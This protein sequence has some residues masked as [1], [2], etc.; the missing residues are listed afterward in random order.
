M[1]WFKVDDKFHSHAKVARLGD[2]SDALALWVV[3]GS[4]CADQLTDGWIPAYVARR[5]DPDSV[6]RAAAL[7]RV[8]LWKE[9]IQEGEKGWL[10]HGWNDEGRQP[11]AE[12][13]QQER[14]LK[15]ERQRRWREKHRAESGR[16][17]VD[18]S[19]ASGAG[20][21]AGDG[22]EFEVGEAENDLM[23]SPHEASTAASTRDGAPES[24]AGQSPKG[25]RDVDASTGRLGD[26]GVDTAPTRP[27]PT[28]DKEQHLPPSAD[29]DGAVNGAAAPKK[30]APDPMLRFPDF[31]AVYPRKVGKQAAEK[32]WA[33]AVKGGADPQAIIDGALAYAYECRLRDQD[34][35]KYPQGWLTDGRWMDERAPTLPIDITPTL[36]PWCGECDET[37]RRRK[38]TD[39]RL[40]ACPDCH[41]DTAGAPR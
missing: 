18:A 22:A 4:W 7:V 12:Q 21:G 35:I 29:A 2:D 26:G 30:R 28:I 37:D 11:T 13:V 15:T 5:L 31:W 10:F 1:T 27:D 41:P 16:F 9:H 33:K 36:P 34:K 32:N 3:A 39:G 24:S 17:A 14:A 40:Y 6:R 38:K 25:R 8:G 19:T 23:R 20:D